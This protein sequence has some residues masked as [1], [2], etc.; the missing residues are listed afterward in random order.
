VIKR[1]LC[2]DMLG[3]LSDLTCGDAWVPQLMR[4]DRAGSSFVISRTPVAEELLETAASCKAVELSELDLQDLLASQ[5]HALF[6]KRKLPARMRLFRLLGRSV[7]AYHQKLLSPTRADYVNTLKLYA[8]R[9]ALGGNQRW[10]GRLFCLLRRRR[11]RT[12]KPG[13][14]PSKL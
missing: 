7:P 4:T 10:F 1:K 8:A 11:R 12:P 13:L 9:F 2:S 14:C 6:K 5:D 3:E